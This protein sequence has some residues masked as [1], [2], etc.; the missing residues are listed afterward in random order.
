M[1]NFHLSDVVGFV[2]GLV[3]GAVGAMLGVVFQGALPWTQR[4]LQFTV[5]LIV[6]HYVGGALL[7]LFPD[8]PTIVQDA[9]KLG[10]GMSAFEGARR[11]RLAAIEVAG[12]APKDL[13]E[14]L[15]SLFGKRK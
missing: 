11:F 7:A 9:I 1:H 12:Q 6:S 14:H 8:W 15:K 2:A 5:G 4:L 10:I 3:P 13:W